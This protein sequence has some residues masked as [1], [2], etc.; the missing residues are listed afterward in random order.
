MHRPRFRTDNSQSAASH[1]VRSVA[2]ALVL[3]ALAGGCGG[4][5][6]SKASTKETTT[7]AATPATSTK[8]TTTTT[9]SSPGSSAPTTAAPGG[10]GDFCSKISDAEVTRALGVDVTRREPHSGT[11]SESCIKGT[12]RQTDLTKAAFVSFSTY[13]A[14]GAMASFEKVK[15]SL[16]GSKV[17]SGLGDQAL[18]NAP[19]GVLI[20]FRGGKVFM[21]Q[22][23]KAGKPGSETDAVT[24]T[25]AMLG[26][27]G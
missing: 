5:S 7:T 2:V 27:L 16:P 3:A 15:T 25:K 26:R 9:A 4:S 18:F 12:Q 8:E 10:G 1:V 19:V 11:G 21:V 20:G 24:L 17:L 6:T 13:P 14:G 22:V 23:F